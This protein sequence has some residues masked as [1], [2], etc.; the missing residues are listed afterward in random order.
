MEYSVTIVL[1]HLGMGVE[2]RIAKVHNLLCKQLNPVGRIAENDRLINLQSGK[3]G[4]ETMNFLAF[5][6]VA[7]ELSYTSSIRFISCGLFI[8]LS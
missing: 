3:E 2:A 4:V 1:Q 7:I 8:C 5:L 6:N